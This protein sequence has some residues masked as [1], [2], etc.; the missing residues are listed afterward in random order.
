MIY[1][2]GS[3]NKT[4]VKVSTRFQMDNFL[5]PIITQESNQNKPLI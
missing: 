4:K 5:L 1:T 3:I 2:V